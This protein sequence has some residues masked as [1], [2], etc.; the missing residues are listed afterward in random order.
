MNQVTPASLS[1]PI[2]V[3]NKNSTLKDFIEFDKKLL[4]KKTSRMTNLIR[5]FD[6][7]S[8]MARE[9]QRRGVNAEGKHALLAYYIF[10]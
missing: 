6:Q 2:S 1:Y 3:F 9:S 8:E 7:E 4:I 5:K 10:T